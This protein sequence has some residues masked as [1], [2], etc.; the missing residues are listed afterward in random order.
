MKRGA[1][2]AARNDSGPGNAG[3]ACAS[4]RIVVVA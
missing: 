4:S 2:R 3:A 1:S